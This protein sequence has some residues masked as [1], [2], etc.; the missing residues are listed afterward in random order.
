MFSEGVEIWVSPLGACVA[1]KHNSV[2]PSN[3][4]AN[5]TST[6][7]WPPLLYLPLLCCGHVRQTTWPLN[8]APEHQQNQHPYELVPRTWELRSPGFRHHSTAGWSPS[9]HRSSSFVV[10]CHVNRCVIQFKC[11]FDSLMGAF[12]SKDS[13]NTI[14]VLSI[15][16]IARA[17]NVL[18]LELSLNY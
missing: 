2:Y 10:E 4:P 1:L 13:N 11:Y 6:T 16:L 3:Y 15:Y 18:F 12:C 8:I 17:I 9:C 5:Q 14:L 7:C